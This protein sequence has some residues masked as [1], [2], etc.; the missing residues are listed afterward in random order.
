MKFVHLAIPFIGVT[1]AA[2]AEVIPKASIL[3]P[4]DMGQAILSQARKLEDDNAEVDYTWVAN[5]SL[6]YQGCYH[7]QVWNGDANDDGNIRISTQRLMLFPLCPSNSCSMTNAAGCGAG[8]GN[9][10]PTAPLIVDYPLLDNRALAPVPQH[11]VGLQCVS[12]FGPICPLWQAPGSFLTA[13]K[14]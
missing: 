13:T 9:Y 14:L 10:S 4:S 5:M 12:R 11:A 6:K 3:V 1:C 8:F 7:T 2:A